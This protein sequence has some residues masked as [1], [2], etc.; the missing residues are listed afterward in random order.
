MSRK[1]NKVHN[2]RKIRRCPNYTQLHQTLNLAVHF[3]KF[4]AFPQS[5]FSNK[6]IQLV[7]QPR[8]YQI[9]SFT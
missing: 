8:D 6:L 5:I 9:Y 7:S 3:R 1:A 4:K 2:Y